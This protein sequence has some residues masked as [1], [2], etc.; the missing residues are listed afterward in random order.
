[1]S[2]HELKVWPEF[3][4]GI[5]SGDK[6][7]ELRRDDRDFKVGDWL[8]LREWAP[9]DIAAAR[10][11]GYTGARCLR[12]ISYVVRAA[13]VERFTVPGRFAD[14]SFAPGA[15]PLG[16]GWVILG[17]SPP[18]SDLGMALQG[19]RLFLGTIE[20]P[21]V[22]A[23]QQ[24][25]AALVAYLERQKQNM[26]AQQVARAHGAHATSADELQQAREQAMEHLEQA[27]KNDLG[28]ETSGRP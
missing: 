21:L 18:I 25:L 12:R 20:R 15:P 4:A 19:K 26:M 8:K 17:L 5:Q 22:R 9:P 16:H 1:M 6:P 28:A 3:F 10:P 14:G 13:D 27:E 24:Y 23:A 2:T 11:G 7:F